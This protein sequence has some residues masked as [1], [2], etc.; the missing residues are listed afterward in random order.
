LSVGITT[1]NCTTLV[2]TMLG[3]PGCVEERGRKDG[4]SVVSNK[5][6]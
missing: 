4:E 1:E 3:R 2:T 6:G 5:I